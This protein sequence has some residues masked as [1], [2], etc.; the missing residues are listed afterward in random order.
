MKKFIFI[1]LSLLSGYGFAYSSNGQQNQMHQQMFDQF[2]QLRISGIQ[3]RISI[4]QNALSCVQGA[5]K[6][7]DMKACEQTAHT[8]MESLKQSQQQKMQALKQTMQQ[9]HQG[10]G[11]QQNTGQQNNAH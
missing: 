7:E 8:A 3:E 2:K 6:R 11:G 10:Q 1:L 5:Q 4:E 9:E